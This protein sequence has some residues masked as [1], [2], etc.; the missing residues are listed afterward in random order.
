MN[1]G[2]LNKILLVGFIFLQVHFISGQIVK[3]PDPNLTIDNTKG[4]LAIFPCLAG[5]LFLNDYYLTEVPANDTVY[6]KD[7]AP[8][9]YNLKFKTAEM[10]FK[11]VITMKHGKVTP[12]N[13][14]LDSVIMTTATFNRD[15]ATSNITGKKHFSLKTGYFY[16]IT[17]FAFLNV[18][19]NGGAYDPTSFFNTF[20]T[21]NGYQVAPGFCTG[22]GVSY[23]FYKAYIDDFYGMAQEAT[24]H[25]LPVF[26]DIRAH[27]PPKGR[28]F[29]F[30]K[31]D[32]GGNIILKKTEMHY[33]NYDDD[34]TYVMERGG[35]YISPG[36]GLRILVNDLIQITASLEY[37]HEKSA[38]NVYYDDKPLVPPYQVDRNSNYFKIC[39]GVGFQYR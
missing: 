39:L 29:P 34:M 9:T 10:T 31:F 26:L 17:Q 2:I 18:D 19:M 33:Q 21:I 3:T 32:I 25:Y 28:V 6:I 37:S 1:Q 24:L 23:S 22:I 38:Y 5:S 35:I 30:F 4:I 7:L 12:V 27:L 8:G 36:F 20:T 11:Q 16:N 13:P 15:I 14:C